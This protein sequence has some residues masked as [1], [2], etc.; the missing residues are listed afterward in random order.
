[1]SA[2]FVATE[3]VTEFALASTANWIR[4]WLARIGRRFNQVCGGIFVAIGA[5]LP[6]RA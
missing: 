6:L 4:P 2:T 5:A 3:V 1:M